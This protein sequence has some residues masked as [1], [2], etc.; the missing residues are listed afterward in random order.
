MKPVTVDMLRA[1]LMTASLMA[2][3]LE[4]VALT[5]LFVFHVSEGT[6]RSTTFRL[7]AIAVIVGG[8]LVT[9]RLACLA[10]KVAVKNRHAICRGQRTLLVSVLPDCPRRPL[11]ILHLRLTGIPFELSRC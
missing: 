11:V 8:V 2:M 10:Y 7:L 1:H 4:A 9:R 6:I 3:I 5:S